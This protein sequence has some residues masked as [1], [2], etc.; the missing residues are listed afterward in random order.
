MK[1]SSLAYTQHNLEWK[2]GFLNGGLHC[3]ENVGG[4]C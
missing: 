1:F 4:W 2:T 3:L